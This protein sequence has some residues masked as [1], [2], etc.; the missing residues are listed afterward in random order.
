MAARFTSLAI[1]KGSPY[2]SQIPWTSGL[3]PSWT[4]CSAST[5]SDATT[6]TEL[7]WWAVRQ[8]TEGYLSN[9]L[10]VLP[11]IIQTDALARSLDEFVRRRFG[12]KTTWIEGNLK[13]PNDRVYRNAYMMVLLDPACNAKVA[14]YLYRQGGGLSNWRATSGA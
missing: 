10:G 1:C 14:A 7:G 12:G 13:D 8:R 9:W 6:A 5:Y 4:G 11:A 3:T 2:E